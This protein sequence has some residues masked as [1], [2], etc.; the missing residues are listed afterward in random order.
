MQASIKSAGPL[1]ALL[2]WMAWPG[3]PA[4]AQDIL[5]TQLEQGFGQNKVRYKDFKW[6]VMESQHLELYYEPEFADL[7]QRAVQYLEEAYTHISQVMHH[8]LSSKPP[9]VIFKSHYEFEQTNIVQ[10]F[11]P[12]GVAGFAE[13]LRYRMVI[14]FDGDLDE[15]RNVLTHELMHIFQYDILY[16]GPIKR[17]SSNPL[18]SPPTWIMEGLAEYATEEMNTIDEMVLRDAV[19]TDELIPLEIMDAA[20]GMGNVFLAYKQSHSLM[21]YI[22]AN[23]GPEKISRILRTWDSQNDTDKL[24]KRLIDLDMD[25]LDER[26]SAQLRK[27][28]WPLLQSRD[29]LAEISHKI[30]KTEDEYQN[31]SNPRWSLSGDMLAVLST[32]G[33]E[34]HVDIIR[35][36]DGSLVERLTSHMRTADYDQLTF[37][38]GTVAWA[39]DGHTIAFVAK[40]GPRDVVLLWDLYDKKLKETLEFDELEIIE[41]LDWAPDSRRLALVGTGDGQSD[42]YVVEVASRQLQQITGTPQRDDYPAWSPDGNHLAFSAK[43]QGQFD[44]KIYDFQ[45]G[46]TQTLVDSPTDDLWPLWM[47]EGNKLLF[48]STREGID[49]LFLYHL[50]EGREYRLT[51]TISGIMTPALSPDGKQLVLVTYYHGRRELYRMDVPSWP[52]IRKRSTI[53]AERAAGHSPAPADSSAQTAPADTAAPP[54][55]MAALPQPLALV[56]QALRSPRAVKLAQITDALPEAAPA[57][58][59]TPALPQ[60]ASPVAADQE[61]ASSPPAATGTDS[62][63]AGSLP[64]HPYTPELE[65]D[66]L[67]VQMGYFDG[68]FS[69]I[70]QLSMSDLLGN[71]SLALSTDY[72]TSQE[73][74]NDFNFALS[75]TYYGQRP[76]YNVVLFNWNQFFNDRQ[77]RLFFYRGRTVR[78]I[79]RSRQSGLLA[80]FSYPL[81]IYRR[82]DLSYTFVDEQSQLVWPADESIESFG[83]HL[84]RA[85][86]VHDSISYGLL[87]PT[88]GR[89]FFLSAG[90]TLTLVE[91]DRSFSHL[92]GDYRHFLRL[93]RWSVLGLR[94][95]GVSSLGRDGLQYNL[96]G[97]AWFLPFYS[98]FNLN[99]GPLR[100]YRFTEFQGTRVVLLNNEVRV[101]FIR[102]ITFGWPGIFAIPAVDGSFFLDIGTAWNEGDSLDLWPL[103][104]PH[105]PL[106]LATPGEPQ[107]QRLHGSVGF[108]ML[109]YFILPMNFEFAKQTDLRGNYSDYKFHFSFGK[110]F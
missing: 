39:P 32:D 104:N 5:T 88:T 71:H 52:E 19:L 20:W 100:G 30:I 2:A 8:E 1:L 94:A 49:D 26:W 45:S 95:T 86:Y 12:P 22:A 93:G 48:V 87:G 81:D 18:N 42:I 109:V 46:K 103:H 10:D 82:L 90:R 56:D 35:L 108:G 68:F 73:I 14:P 60:P 17:L 16:K 4:S 33:V 50:E 51:R 15:F 29:Y 69:S 24:L 25:D 40:K 110:S 74:D 61:P 21:Q 102:N 34:E 106:S 44:I 28:Y 55:A 78:G 80:N 105:D 85:A 3:T 91:G 64:H 37:G 31:Y 97:P 83:T 72:V 63:L 58:Q 7:A 6:M 9:I 92:E 107:E 59:P 27:H 43:Q 84:F 89:R 38:S 23:Y 98:G 67:S 57:E 47:P 77:D 65:F 96:G 70:A 66:G 54:V 62:A 53:L 13:P 101:P 41:S 75:Y 99:M 76:T 36:D 79:E 11:L